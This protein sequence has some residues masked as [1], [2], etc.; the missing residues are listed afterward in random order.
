[1]SDEATLSTTSGQ[2]VVNAQALGAEVENTQ[3]GGKLGS[4]ASQHLSPQYS[5]DVTTWQ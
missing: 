3:G 5:P 1:V 4:G 2:S